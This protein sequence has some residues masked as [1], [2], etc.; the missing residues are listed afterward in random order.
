MRLLAGK[1]LIAH[2]IEQ[3]LSTTLITRIVVSTEDSEIAGVARKFGAQVVLRPFELA[4]DTATSESALLHVLDY[5]YNQEKYESDIVV[6]LQ[7]TS[8]IRRP[9][10]IDEAI[11]LFLREKADSLLS[12]TPWHGFIWRQKERQGQPANFNYQERSR[13]QLLEEEYRENGS[14]FIFKPWV[15]RQFNNRLGGKIILYPMNV[16]SAFETDTLEDFAI[17]EWILQNGL[18]AISA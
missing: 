11:C 6:F 1:P 12:V 7:C 13:R 10:D 15:L 9:D 18:D 17:C 5:L 4:T 2:T 3:A 14:I 8:P 16:W